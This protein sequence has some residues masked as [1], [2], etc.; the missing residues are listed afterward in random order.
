M[1]TQSR[2][3]QASFKG[4]VDNCTYF[5]CDKCFI[6]HNENSYL[7]GYGRFFEVILLFLSTLFIIRKNTQKIAPKLSHK[8][9]QKLLKN[10][11]C[12]IRNYPLIIRGFFGKFS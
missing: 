8:F 9:F 10:L 4:G 2:L 11:Q 7:K 5:I 12:R 3:S 6:L 1:T